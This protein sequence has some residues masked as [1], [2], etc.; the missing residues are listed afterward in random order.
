[1][2]L[3]KYYIQGSA[4]EPYELLVKR[5]GGKIFVSCDCPAG[6][7]LQL[8]K[9]KLWLIELRVD[10]LL[11]EKSDDI[12]K[13]NL[14]FAESEYITL[15]DGLKNLEAQKSSIESDISSLKKRLAKSM[16]VGI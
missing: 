1:M 12:S 7:K 13:L 10:S 3:Y 14:I 5:E 6:Q 11:L 4:S 2:E 8:C 9:H 15:L 16:L